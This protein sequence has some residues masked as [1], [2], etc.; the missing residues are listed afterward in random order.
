MPGVYQL[1]SIKASGLSALENADL[2][3]AAL[4]DRPRG[5]QA[6]TPGAA[7]KRFAQFAL[8][9]VRDDQRRPP[10]H[11]LTTTMVIQDGDKPPRT[12]RARSKYLRTPVVFERDGRRIEVRYRTELLN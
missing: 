6:K 3:A 7:A 11:Q 12:Y 8:E 2:L 1:R 4:D 9:H 5:R 10:P